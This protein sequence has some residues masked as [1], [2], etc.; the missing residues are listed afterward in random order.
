[1]ERVMTAA[2]RFEG[3]AYAVLRIVAGLMFSAHGMQKLFGWFG[4]QGQPPMGSLVWFAG[5]IEI[6]CGLLIA[7]GLFTRPAAF[8]AAGEMAV[9]YFMVHWQLQMGD[10]K[11]MPLV[12]QG[13]L[14]ALYCFLF[15][16][17][18]ARGPGPASLASAVRRTTPTPPE[19]AGTRAPTYAREQGAE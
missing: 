10:G 3:P 12:N 6:V 15:L 9:A 16:Y 19:P 14:A 17:V 2:S 7:L 1:M 4:A 8:L 18:L 13:E 11:W 5:V